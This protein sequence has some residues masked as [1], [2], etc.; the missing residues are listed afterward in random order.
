MA[1][2]SPLD[3]AL[4]KAPMNIII[5]GG[6]NTGLMNGIV[7]KRL[8]HNVRILE[9]N[10]QSERAD[11]AAG[12]TTYP[13]FEEFMKVHDQTG[14]PWSVHSPAIQ[15]L[16]KDAGV[17]RR[18]NK[19]LQMTSWS[20]IYYRL[21]ANFDGLA[22]GFCAKP[23]AAGEHDGSAIFDLGKQVTR[24]SVDG[25]VRV[26][27]TDLAD[28]DKPAEVTADMV[29]LADGANSRLRHAL[30]PEVERRYAGYVAFRGTVPESEVSEETKKA[31]DPNLTY[32]CFKGKYILLYIIPGADGSLAPGHRRYNWVWYHP[33]AARSQSFTDIMTDASGAVHRNTLPAGSMNPRAWENYKTIARLQMCAP[34]AEVVQKTSQ[35]FVT[36]ISDLA[37][38][39][40]VALGGKALIAGEALNLVRPHMAL[41]TTASAAQALLLGQAFGGALTLR[42]WER[43]VLYDGQL[44]ALKTNAFGT[45]FL[46]GFLTAAGWVG[47]LLFAVVRGSLPRGA[48]PDS[49][50]GPAEVGA[51][52]EGKGE[53]T[54]KAK[55]A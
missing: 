40:A 45:F 51:D 50:S 15:W 3:V 43:R 20:V 10:T 23:P 36:A 2:P 12:I 34:F 42:E 35:P 19:P 39:R 38:P 11:L 18:L 22:S 9:Q 47:R 46:Y 37:C 25:G 14:E 29:I 17:T 26:E 21:R 41:S 16:N 44:S 28:G 24:L 30:F 33:I 6:S 8:G 55:T 48:L 7:L 54:G 1:S 53:R 5:I 13:E 52:A 27:Y 49:S 32:F 4:P 31:F